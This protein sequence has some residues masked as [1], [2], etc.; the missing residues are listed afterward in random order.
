MK[1]HEAREPTPQPDDAGAAMIL[2]L[3]SAL[4]IA[5]A[6]LVAAPGTWIWSLQ[7]LRFTPPAIGWP[8]MALAAL[9]I[10]PAVA[11]FQ[12]PYLTRLEAWFERAPRLSTLVGALAVT[13]AVAALPDRTCYVGDFLL[14]AGVLQSGRDI[15]VISPQSLPLDRLIHV[16]LPRLLVQRGW[17]ALPEQASRIVD[18][19]EAGLFAW[20]AL[21]LGRE[22]SGGRG[23]AFRFTMALLGGVALALFTGYAKSACDLCVLTTLFVLGALRMSRGKGAVTVSAAL[24]L[25]LASHRSALLLVPAWLAVWVV[26]WRGR[27]I[28]WRD[29]RTMVALIGPLAMLIVWGPRFLRILLAFDLSHHL[30]GPQVAGAGGPLAA[31]FAP[32]HLL[33]VAN[34]IM[35]YAP[36]APLAA[37]MFARR[38][39]GAAANPEPVAPTIGVL[40]LSALGMALLVHPQ[41]GVYRDW[42]VFA[43]PGSVFA[44]LTAWAV[45]ALASREAS[46]RA[47]A[48]V[49]W[50]AVLSAGLWLGQAADTDRGLQ[51]ALAFVLEPPKRT[52]YERGKTWEFLGDRYASLS[53]WE[54]AAASLQQAVVDQ[55]SP[56]LFRM[57]GIAEAQRGRWEAS[58]AAIYEAARRDPSDTTTWAVLITTATTRGDTAMARLAATELRRVSPHHPLAKETLGAP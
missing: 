49:V 42:D 38:G 37:L 24:A 39:R 40:A 20:V 30:A 2:G 15:A 41:Q 43:I 26:A 56:R 35:A 11:R 9:A 48:A 6:A 16:D 1:P 46:R 14:R 23:L 13:M 8:L 36:M 50:G 55:P 5:R 25:A 52:G 28:E 31:A 3:L 29:P 22:L 17:A 51:R 21:A 19:V 27:R 45:A 53:R 57:L 4:V 10:V 44:I 7:P 34:L 54:E 32:I 12:H 58:E 18:A 47:S 33:D